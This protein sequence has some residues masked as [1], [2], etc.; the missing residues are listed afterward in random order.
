MVNDR[1]PIEIKARR[2]GNGFKICCTSR[3]GVSFHTLTREQVVDM[4]NEQLEAFLSERHQSACV[5][6]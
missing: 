2:E 1:L 5:N 3:L 6:N 4:T